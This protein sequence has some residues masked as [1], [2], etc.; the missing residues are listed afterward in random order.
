MRKSMLVL[1]QTSVRRGF[2]LCFLFC[3]ATAAH[4][5]QLAPS[6]DNTLYESDLPISDGAGEHFFVGTTPESGHRRGL[7]AFDIAGNLP[8]GSTI[9]TVTLRLHVS[10]ERGTATIEL[11]RALADWGEGSSVAP[12]GEGGG[13]PASLGDVTWLNT[14]WDET[15]SP[16]TWD[17]P[18]GVGHAC[19]LVRQ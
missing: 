18:G 10:H 9:Q 6:K 17:H 15:E 7:I 12:R 14:F 4:V 19:S 16:P 1:A 13:D 8:S 11:H 3:G 5:I 2:I